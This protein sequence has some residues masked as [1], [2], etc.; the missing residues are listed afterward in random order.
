[1][2]RNECGTEPERDSHGASPLPSSGILDE[3]GAGRGP[4]VRTPRRASACFRSP[5]A[6]RRSALVEQQAAQ[7]PQVVEDAAAGG[8]VPLQLRQLVFHETQRMLVAFVSRA[9]EIE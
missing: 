8:E 6:G 7:G 3:S 4:R 1:R 5:S 9:L 2:C